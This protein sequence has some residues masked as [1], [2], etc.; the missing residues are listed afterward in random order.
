MRI[1][2]SGGEAPFVKA[3]I[4][5]NGAPSAKAQLKWAGNGEKP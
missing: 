1:D 4:Y 2:R 3:L 5:R